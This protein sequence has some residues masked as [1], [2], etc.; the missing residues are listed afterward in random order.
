MSSA[1][2]SS[3]AAAASRTV[4]RSRCRHRRPGGEGA[5]AASTARSTSGCPAA[6]GRADD[7]AIAGIL[8]REGLFGSARTSLPPITSLARKPGSQLLADARA[9]PCRACRS[10]R[11]PGFLPA[12][13]ASSA[14]PVERPAGLPPSLFGKPWQT[15]IAFVCIAVITSLI[16][17]SQSRVGAIEGGG[18][19]RK[20]FHG[21]DAHRTAAGRSGRRR[22]RNRRQAA[23]RDFRSPR[24]PLQRHRHD[25]D[26]GGR[27]RGGRREAAAHPW[28]PAGSQLPARRAAAV[29]SAS[30]AAIGAIRFGEPQ[31]GRGVVRAAKP[32]ARRRCGPSQQID[33]IVY[34]PLNKHAMKLGGFDEIDEMH[35]PRPASSACAAFLHR[36]Q[37]TRRSLDHA[38]HLACADP[39]IAALITQRTHHRCHAARGGDHA[40]GGRSSGR[41][42]LSPASIPHAGDGGTIGQED[43][44]SSHLPSRT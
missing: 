8:H 15:A 17:A 26:A 12:A 31:S 19:R 33:A 21:A 23:G 11:H 7:L 14:P 44:N 29:R 22:T 32:A 43:M 18:A 5:A 13:A 27:R 9:Q 39:G 42:S 25:G 4:L 24:H 10:S 41:A 37:S 6:G 20:A 35:I 1:S 30:D 34:A 40:A 3:A 38:C 2:R 16:R 28:S 36:A